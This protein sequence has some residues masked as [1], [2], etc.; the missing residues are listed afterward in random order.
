MVSHFLGYSDEKWKKVIF[1][2]E[3]T[4]EIFST[5]K[6]QHI[7]RRN[8]ETLKECN[9]LPT[10]KYGGGKIMVWGCVSYQGIGNLVFIE[11][12]LNSSKNTNLLAN[13]L[14]ISAKK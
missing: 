4:F 7:Y 11:G 6:H 12:N 5:K 10:F 8:G 2:D 3:S 13:N 1:S 9:L 14:H